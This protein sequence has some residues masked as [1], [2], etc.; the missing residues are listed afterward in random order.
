MTESLKIRKKTK[1]NPSSTLIKTFIHTETWLMFENLI[2]FV[3][4]QHYGHVAF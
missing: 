2:I 4:K 3:R 1:P